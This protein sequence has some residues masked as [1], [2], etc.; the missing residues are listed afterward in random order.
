MEIFTRG[1]FRPKPGFPGN[2][3]AKVNSGVDHAWF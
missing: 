3:D 1:V 2:L